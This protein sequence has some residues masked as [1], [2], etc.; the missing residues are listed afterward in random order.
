MICVKTAVFGQLENNCYLLTDDASGK[1]ALVDCTDASD[2]M[3]DFIGHANPEYIFFF[4]ICVMWQYIII[5][6]SSFA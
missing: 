1:S 2:K 3:I 4:R 5:I 6:C